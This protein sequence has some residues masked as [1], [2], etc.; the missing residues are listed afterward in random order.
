MK[1]NSMTLTDMMHTNT[2]F[3]TRIHALENANHNVP[4]R[5]CAHTDVYSTVP[6][7]VGKPNKLSNTILLRMSQDRQHHTHASTH[8]PSCTHTIQHVPEPVLTVLCSNSPHLHS[9]KQAGQDDTTFVSRCMAVWMSVHADTRTNTPLH[10]H[11]TARTQYCESKHLPPVL[12]STVHIQY[13]TAPP[14]QQ[15]SKQEASSVGTRVEKSAA[16]EPPVFSKPTSIQ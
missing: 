13:S 4:S 1:N 15:E 6:R 5:Y 11:L 12:C 7:P 2:R 3:N 9:T 16:H 14:S 10:I 8:T